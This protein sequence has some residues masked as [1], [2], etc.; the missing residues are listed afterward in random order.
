MNTRVAML[1]GRADPRHDGVADYTV[2]LCAALRAEGT[3]VVDVPVDP[4]AAG[5]WRA[6]RAVRDARPDVVHLQFA[7]S[8]FGFSGWPGALPDLCGRRPLVTTVHEYGWWSWA[9]RVPAP[10]WRLV[11]RGGVLDRETARLVP[12][13]DAVLATNDDHA[14]ALSARLGVTAHPAPLP[15]NV[16]VDPSPPARDAVRA[17]LGVPRDAEVVAFFGFVHPVKGLRHLVEAMARLRAERPRLH[18]LVVGG[19]TSLALPADEAAAFR[20]ELVGQIAEIGETPHVTITGH[21]PA[22]RVSAAL[23]AADLAAFPFT[24]GAT[25]KSGAL[26]AA[27]QHGLPTLVTRRGDAG[28]DA[29][30]VDGETVVVAPEVRDDVALADGLRRLLDDPDRAARIGAAGR[31]AVRDRTWAGLAAD[32]RELYGSLCAP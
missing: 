19:F 7:P 21:L 17:E 20:A 25:L 28:P 10:L 23:A 9:P 29:D 1:H 6:A 18:L 5:T 31:D 12:R 26:L 3:D 2:Q 14:R 8:A 27:L 15:P 11:E 32:H 4:G 30:L 22:G 24:A 13:S 16:A